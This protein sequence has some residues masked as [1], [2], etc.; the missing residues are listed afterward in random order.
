MKLLIL[1][2]SIFYLLGLKLVA[3][4]EKTSVIQHKTEVI[5]MKVIED[6]KVM[7]AQPA[8]E[9]SKKGNITSTKKD[10]TCVSSAN[11]KKPHQVTG[12]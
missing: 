12:I 11:N 1:S 9:I 4:V 8:S 6:K 2:T 10:S 3:N 7:S 5:K